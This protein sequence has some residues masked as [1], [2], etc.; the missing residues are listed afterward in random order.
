MQ[1]CGHDIYK[2]H[3]GSVYY[4]IVERLKWAESGERNVVYHLLQRRHPHHRRVAQAVA[5][6]LV[7][8]KIL[9]HCHRCRRF[10]KSRPLRAVDPILVGLP[11]MEGVYHKAVSRHNGGVLDG[12]DAY[13]V[14]FMAVQGVA[15]GVGY[16]KLGSERLH[17]IH[18]LVHMVASQSVATGHEGIFH[19][20]KHGY[21]MAVV[22]AYHSTRYVAVLINV[23]RTQKKHLTAIKRGGELRPCRHH[24]VAS[25]VHRGCYVHH[26]AVSC[27]YH[28]K[29]AVVVVFAVCVHL[30]GIA[31]QNVIGAK[32]LVGQYVGGVVSV[33]PKIGGVHRYSVA[34]LDMQAF[35]GTAKRGGGGITLRLWNGYHCR[36]TG[37]QIILRTPASC[38]VGYRYGT[39]PCRNYGNRQVQSVGREALMRVAH[40]RKP[41]IGA[42]GRYIVALSHRRRYLQQHKGNHCHRR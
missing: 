31:L 13:H 20:G 7:A 5:L 17:R 35:V 8:H 32:Q 30:G 24:S 37:R 34:G 25:K 4:R 19:S 3:F 16:H 39:C 36:D 29:T 21:F 42:L 11:R 23:V 38:V 28:R 10:H 18:L 12:G 14:E 2:M 27:G 6:H 41:E 22:G 1:G 15:H 40:I 26:S 33:G 9:E